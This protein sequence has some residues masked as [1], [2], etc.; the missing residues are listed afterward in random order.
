MTQE[1]DSTCGAVSAS[2]VR[3]E[4]IEV[5]EYIG[6]ATNGIVYF[7][8]VFYGYLNG[9]NNVDIKIDFSIGFNVHPEFNLLADETYAAKFSV[10]WIEWDDSASN[11]STMKGYVFGDKEIT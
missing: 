4:P 9:N 11:L 2:L 5:Q 7:D 3:T 6:F 10:G 1:N 8:G